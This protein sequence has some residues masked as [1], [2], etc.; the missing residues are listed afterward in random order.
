MHEHNMYIN[1][2]KKHSQVHLSTLTYVCI[3][4][5]QIYMNIRTCNMLA[6]I[7]LCT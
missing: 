4:D 6:L 1:M 5:D 2:I 7:V 3:G